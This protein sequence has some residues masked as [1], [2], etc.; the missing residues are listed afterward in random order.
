MGYTVEELSDRMEINDLLIRYAS[1]IDSR[2]W[3]QLDTC[4]TPDAEVDYASS[5]GIAGKYPEVRAWLEKS[6]AMF[7][8]TVHYIS[9]STISLEGDRASGRTL[10]INPMAFPKDE[11]DLDILTVGAYYYDQ[12]VRTDE[13]WRIASRREEQLFFDGSLTEAL[14]RSSL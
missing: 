7:H 13:G 3:D 12:L 2:D 10:V 11:G 9:N 5:G 1:A 14:K 4:F 6:L 8:V